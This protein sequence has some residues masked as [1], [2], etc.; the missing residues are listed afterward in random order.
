MPGSLNVYREVPNTDESL[1]W[2]FVTH[3]APRCLKICA[4]LNS[5]MSFVGRGVIVFK[6]FLASFYQMP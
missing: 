5:S 1:V 6:M 4:L 3:L 2:N